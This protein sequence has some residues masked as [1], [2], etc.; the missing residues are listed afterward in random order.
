MA[1]EKGQTVRKLAMAPSPS[2]L[3]N[4]SSACGQAHRGCSP[5]SC[6]LATLPSLRTGKTPLHS[7]QTQF[8]PRLHLQ[9]S[10]KGN[11]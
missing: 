9:C 1:G 2:V 8:C 4:H 6:H 3:Q 5:S 10:D 11:P 7:S